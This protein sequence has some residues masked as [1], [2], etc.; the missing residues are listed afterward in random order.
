MNKQLATL[1]AAMVLETVSETQ[2]TF[3]TPSG[4]MYAALMSRG[5]SLNDYQALIDGLVA[6]GFLTQSG[7]CL[8][9]TT[10]K[11]QALKAVKS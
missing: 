1:L 2:G 3:G 5:I 9:K 8:L 4:P 11:Y 7:S 10:K 6:S